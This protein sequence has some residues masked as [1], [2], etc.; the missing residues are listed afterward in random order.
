MSGIGGS[1]R[2]LKLAVARCARLATRARDAPEW[3]GGGD[4]GGFD[5]G[6]EEGDEVFIEGLGKE[7]LDGGGSGERG[8]RSSGDGEVDE[9][10]GEG[11]LLGKAGD[12]V[13]GEAR[14]IAAAID[15]FVVIDH[16][17]ADCGI[18]DTD[19]AE[20]A[21]GGDRVG[22][23]DVAFGRG[24]GAVHG[25]QLA[26]T[27][28]DPDIGDDAGEECVL[29]GLRITLGES[30]C[31]RE[32]AG[33]RGAGDGAHLSSGGG[34]Q[35]GKGLR[36]GGEEAGGGLEGGEELRGTT[37][38]GAVVEEAPRLQHEAAVN[39]G[40]AVREWDAVVR[41]DG[42]GMTFAPPEQART[43]LRAHVE[44][45]VQ[46]RVKVMIEGGRDAKFVA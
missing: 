8:P 6:A 29:S 46:H 26:V 44:D 19:A 22:G 23:D 33:A 28:D 12:I 1:S 39:E 31:G 43:V 40:G 21:R 14:R 17:V 37:E 30:E 34:E 15:A 20:E 18:V 11:E 42:V 27:I 24:E 25:H 38:A 13:A 35:R 36:V 7:L 10:V 4:L 45:G 16:G 2:R 41:R 5:E 9:R 32:Q 3:L